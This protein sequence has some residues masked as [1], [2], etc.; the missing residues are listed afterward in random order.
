M[1]TMYQESWLTLTDQQAVNK[2]K[3][4]VQRETDVAT[5]ELFEWSLAA[6]VYSP[7]VAAI[8]QWSSEWVNDRS[9]GL[10][11]QYGSNVHCWTNQLDNIPQETIQPVS[12]DHCY[13]NY[14][15]ILFAYGDPLNPNMYSELE[16]LKTWSEKHGYGFAYRYVKP[17]SVNLPEILTGYGVELMIKNSEYKVVDDRQTSGRSMTSNSLR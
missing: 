13:G 16:S 17:F 8:W 11:I 1:K 5:V 7:K 12:L 4:W 9:C 14:P 3:Q 15:K 2:A 6:K 10:I